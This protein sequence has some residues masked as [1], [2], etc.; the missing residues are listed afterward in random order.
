M[1][2]RDALSAFD[3][4]L[5]AC[6]LLAAAAW[7]WQLRARG[8][9]S[10]PL[11]EAAPLADGY[12]LLQAVAALTA[13]FGLLTLLQPLLWR[14]D[15]GELSSPGAHAWHWLQ[16][17]DAFAKLVAALLMIG[18]VRANRAAQRRGPSPAALAHAPVH[19][20]PPHSAAHSTAAPD[21]DLQTDPA[22]SSRGTAPSVH[23]GR[24]IVVSAAIATLIVLPLSTSQLAATHELR[25]WWQ[26][27]Y[28][29][30]PH[31]VLQAL[32]QT[33]WGNWG[34][35]QL[36]VLAVLVAPLTEELLFRGLLLDALRSACGG[37]AWPAILLSAAAF[38]AIHAPPE[39]ILPI[40][41]LGI[42][43]GVLR[44]YTN[45]LTACVLAHCLFN[46]RTMLY[47][48]ICPEMLDPLRP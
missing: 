21:A 23:S 29:P 36:C 33:A 24:R 25:G 1:I 20:S 35:A 27:D 9:L 10:T 8:L 7:L 6:G 45:S 38:G 16:M 30:A 15:R 4:T 18:F 13:Y 34:A 12:F 47:V 11:A 19:G 37:L 42:V 32:D 28:R 39:T 5:Q 43:L 48:L 41:T 40:V 14:F 3:M 17:L 26:P 46:G 2:D 44:L 22:P 31:A